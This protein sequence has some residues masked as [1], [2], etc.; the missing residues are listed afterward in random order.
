MPTDCPDTPSTAPAWVEPFLA[1]L[2][3]GEG[4]RRARASAGVAGSTLYA[5][6]KRD[7]SFALDWLDAIRP[8]R[9]PDDRRAQA[10]RKGG[11]TKVDRFMTKLTETSNVALAAEHAG[12]TP[13]WVYKRRR[14]DR[15]FARRWQVALAEGY[16]NLEMEVLAKM[17]EGADA[18][19]GHIAAALRCIAAHREA[20][21]REKGR[22]TLEDEV[23]TIQSINAKIDR[24]RL[25]TEAG[26]AAIAKARE[27]NARRR[28]AEAGSGKQGFPQG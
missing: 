15:D 10:P 5:R 26:K 6:R 27:E 21:A 28:A 9:K 16:D 17:R 7:Q 8:H 4:V 2:R 13:S 18:S 22:R 11:A 19:K 20:V 12:V 1:A 24:L 23:I 3:A 25:N 14:E